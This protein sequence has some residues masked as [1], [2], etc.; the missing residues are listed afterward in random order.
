MEKCEPISSWPPQETCEEVEENISEKAAASGY[1]FI[2]TTD[3][4]SCKRTKLLASNSD[5]QL[6]SAVTRCEPLANVALARWW[7]SEGRHLYSAKMDI[8]VSTNPNTQLKYIAR[9]IFHILHEL[10]YQFFIT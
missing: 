9:Y 8:P 3:A 7:R 5:E 2:D 10:F 4:P 6:G 1:H